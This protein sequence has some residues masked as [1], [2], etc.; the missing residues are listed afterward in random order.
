LQTRNNCEKTLQD[1]IREKELSYNVDKIKEE[2]KGMG[3]VDHRTSTGTCIF[4]VRFLTDKEQEEREIQQQDEMEDLG[5]MVGG[6][7]KISGEDDDD[8]ADDD[9]ADDDDD[10][11]DDD[12]EE[13]Q[14]EEK[15]P[16]EFDILGKKYIAF[17]MKEG[18]FYAKNKDGSLGDEVG[19]FETD[20]LGNTTRKFCVSKKIN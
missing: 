4:G 17:D 19:Y 18:S 14:E 6:S 8:E 20:D 3:Y 10:D 12:D 7:L 1:F 9:E 11:D 15:Q 5:R 13:G 16:I 2:L